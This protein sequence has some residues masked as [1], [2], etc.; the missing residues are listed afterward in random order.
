MIAFM[1][2]FAMQA[3]FLWLPIIC[4]QAH[5]SEVTRLIASDDSFERLITYISKQ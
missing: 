3:D 2:C 5:K 1:V 4:S